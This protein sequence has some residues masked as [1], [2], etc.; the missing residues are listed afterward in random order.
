MGYSKDELKFLEKPNVSFVCSRCMQS[1]TPEVSQGIAKLKECFY[2]ENVSG[3]Y[4][5]LICGFYHLKGCVESM[6]IMAEQFLSASH[7]HEP[8]PEDKFS[9]VFEC[10][11]DYDQKKIQ[12]DT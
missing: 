4:F 10:Q 7:Q 9:K 2:V 8:S 3:I 6:K 5:T 1:P 11:I 12:S